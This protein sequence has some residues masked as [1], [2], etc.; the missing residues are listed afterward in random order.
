MTST[1]LTS[2]NTFLW[3]V[4]TSCPRVKLW[5]LTTFATELKESI[6]WCIGI[7]FQML[8]GNNSLWIITYEREKE[9]REDGWRTATAAW[10]LPVPTSHATLCDAVNDAKNE[11]NDSGYLGLTLEYSSACHDVTQFCDVRYNCSIAGGIIF[12]V[13]QILLNLCKI[14]W[15]Q[16]CHG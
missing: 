10:P 16:T 7:P 5:I 12:N 3:W 9:W 11:N 14:N 8:K 6:L 4:W 2:Y 15:P 13:T 1:T